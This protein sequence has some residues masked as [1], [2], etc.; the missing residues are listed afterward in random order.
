MLYITFINKS[1]LADVSD[2][3]VRA[4]VN[5]REIAGPFKVEGHKRADGW[6]KLLEQ[7]VE[8]QKASKA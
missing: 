4:F 6:L 3:E 2:Y 7:F 1:D 5:D 8:E